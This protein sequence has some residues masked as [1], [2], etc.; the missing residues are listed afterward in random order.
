MFFFFILE[1]MYKV[2]GVRLFFFVVVWVYVK[3]T[4]HVFFFLLFP[5]FHMY[6]FSRSHAEASFQWLKKKKRNNSFSGY[7]DTTY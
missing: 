2:R 5:R 7:R 4:Q 1:L 6:Y 3:T